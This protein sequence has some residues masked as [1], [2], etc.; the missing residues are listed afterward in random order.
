MKFFFFSLFLF[1][2]K[3]PQ[4]DDAIEKKILFVLDCPPKD[5]HTQHGRFFCQNKT[6]LNLNVFFFFKASLLLACTN[7][8]GC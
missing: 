7:Y 8:N 4:T 5:E 3:I 1:F 6:K 2:S